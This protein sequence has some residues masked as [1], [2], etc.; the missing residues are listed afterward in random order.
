MG[1]ELTRE[2]LPMRERNRPG[3]TAV[4]GYEFHPNEQQL[5]NGVVF[6]ALRVVDLLLGIGVNECGC[7]EASIWIP[8]QIG[9]K[10]ERYI[11]GKSATRLQVR[12]HV[13]QE[14]LDISRR[15]KVE[16]HV[17]RRDDEGEP[18]PQI[19]VSHVALLETNASPDVLG[20]FLQPLLEVV[21]HGPREIDAVNRGARPGNG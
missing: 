2:D 19:D 11:K 7:F 21:E 13:L 16:H 15:V 14:L 12:N 6:E 18:L 17:E 1:L 10:W 4:F 20:S 8:R 5:T 9:N 3:L